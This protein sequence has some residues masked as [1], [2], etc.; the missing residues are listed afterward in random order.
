MELLFFAISVLH[1]QLGGRNSVY[2]FL[3]GF[4]ILSCFSECNTLADALGKDGASHFTH[5]PK[6]IGK[7]PFWSMIHTKSHNIFFFFFW[8]IITYHTTI[9]SYLQIWQ[10]QFLHSKLLSFTQS[11]LIFCLWPTNYWS[12]LFN[13][14]SLKFK[15]IIYLTP[16]LTNEHHIIYNWQTP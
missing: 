4:L 11:L 1:G 13:R 2:F 3:N 6:K 8:K 14:L 9:L 7:P 16:C 10:T 5:Y 15:L 12:I